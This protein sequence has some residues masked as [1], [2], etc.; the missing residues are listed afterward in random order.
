[1]IDDDSSESSSKSSVH[2]ENPP[3]KSQDSFEDMDEYAIVFPP[4][5]A[6]KKSVCDENSIY[7]SSS[8]ELKSNDNTQNTG[9]EMAISEFEQPR[10]RKEEN[11]NICSPPNKLRLIHQSGQCVPWQPSAPD[12]AA[13]DEPIPLSQPILPV[14]PKPRQ[15]KAQP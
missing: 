7:P 2:Q 14:N 10:K 5:I 4:D 6:G 13:L 12:E 3:P 1:M 15:E 9:G 11:K 8:P